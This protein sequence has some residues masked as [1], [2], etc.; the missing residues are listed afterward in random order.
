MKK[1]PGDSKPYPMPTINDDMVTIQ[2]IG[3]GRPM[4]IKPGKP[5]RPM[6]IKPGK[7]GAIKPFPM[8]R[9]KDDMGMKEEAKKRA[10]KMMMGRNK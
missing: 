8:P 2:P 9:M 6:P 5:G 10:L 3:P 4:P 1:K 7:P